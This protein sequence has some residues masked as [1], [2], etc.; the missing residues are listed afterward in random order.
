MTNNT[1]DTVSELLELNTPEL[2]DLEKVE[3]V[4]KEVG[5]SDTLTTVKWLVSN[6]LE[7]H[8]E[9]CEELQ[10]EPNLESWVKDKTVLWTVLELLKTVQ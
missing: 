6:L 7:F 9:K 3:Q 2:T 10:C 5:Y 8:T 4:M 1:P